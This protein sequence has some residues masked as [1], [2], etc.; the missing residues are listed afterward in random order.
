MKYPTNHTKRSSTS[1]LSP[2]LF[3]AGLLA[4]AAQ[5]GLA[6]TNTNWFK[7]VTLT[8]NNVVQ[9]DA[10]L[11]G[12][13]AASADYLFASRVGASDFRRWDANALANPMSIESGFIIVSDLRTEKV[14]AF[15]NEEGTMAGSGTATALHEL[16]PATGQTNGVVIPLSQS[17]P[18]EDSCSPE[19]GIFCGWGRVVVGRSQLFDITL[20]GGQVTALAA[21]NPFDQFCDPAEP[22]TGVAEFFGDELYLVACQPF[23]GGKFERVRLSN[24]ARTTVATFSDMPRNTKIGFSPSRHRWYFSTESSWLGSA[25]ETIGYADATWDQSDE[26]PLPPP[27]PPLRVTTTPEP[28]TL[29]EG[30]SATVDLAFTQRPDAGLIRLQVVA[31]SNPALLPL[32]RVTRGPFSGG[33]PKPPFN[34]LTTGES[35]TQTATLTPV[36]GQFGTAILTFLSTNSIGERVTNLVTVTVTPL[37]N[38]PNI[39]FRSYAAPAFVPPAHLAPLTPVRLTNMFAVFDADQPTNPPTFRFETSDP[40]RLPLSGMSVVPDGTNFQFIVEVP[41]GQFVTAGRVRL[42][43]TDAGGLEDSEDAHFS[44]FPAGVWPAGTVT[45]ADFHVFAQG[46]LRGRTGTSLIVTGLVGQVRQAWL[47]THAAIN[48]CYPIL[49]T[50]NLGSPGRTFEVVGA[51]ADSC[52]STNRSFLTRCDVSDLVTSNGVYDLGGLFA[53]IFNPVTLEQTITMTANGISLLVFC[54]DGNPTNDVNV[55][56]WHGNDSNEDGAIDP[57]GWQTLLDNL[58]YTGGV[59]TLGLHVAYGEAILDPPVLVNGQPWLPENDFFSGATVS[60][61]PGSTNAQFWDV[62]AFDLAP[63]LTPGVNHLL[64]TSWRTTNSHDC[65]NL[66][67]ATVA[68]PVAA[69]PA[70]RLAVRNL[71]AGQIEISWSPHTPGFVLQSTDSLLPPN[72]VNAPGGAT[73]PVIVPAA[74]PTKF[75]RLFKP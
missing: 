31:S 15:A 39:V 5:P 1:K 72:W 3:A 25:G 20:P 35:G 47:Y 41:A 11:A 75:Y 21:G 55:T 17:V 34:V 10:G 9:T 30:G 50:T 58:A 44:V 43:C 4:A 49:G 46:G 36:P 6:A 67:L 14:Y 22:L 57:T 37:N 52:E 16:D 27:P 74:F 48:P 73:N 42:I 26:F 70:P 28:V 24:F 40:V 68:Q 13:L 29:V 45:N 8:T 54:D 32:E 53:D 60:A 61:P 69:S 71:G 64:L 23:S 19:F 66:C 51:A 65:L 62:R 59:A 56:L 12:N 7:I 33:F 18:V 2:W 63:R 38:P